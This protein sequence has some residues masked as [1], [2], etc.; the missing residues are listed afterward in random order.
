[1]Q[2]EVV[3]VEEHSMLHC[4][5]GRSR[6]EITVKEL[7]VTNFDLDHVVSGPKDR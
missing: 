7:V 5:L 3:I 4:A 2:F 1:M 6:E